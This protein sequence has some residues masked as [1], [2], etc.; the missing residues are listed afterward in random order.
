METHEGLIGDTPLIELWG[1]VDRSM[2][3]ELLD[4][5]LLLV[6]GQH[7]LLFDC[8]HLTYLDSG[9]VAV[10]YQVLERLP[11]DDGAWLGVLNPSPNVRRILDLVGLLAQPNFRLFPS[12]RE[13]ERAVGRAEGPQ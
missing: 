11:S 12:R 2:S 8:S 5:S 7:N 4:R 9:A 6:E 3:E 10:L 13:A 1:E